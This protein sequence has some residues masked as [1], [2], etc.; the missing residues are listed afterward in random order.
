MS[1]LFKQ[2]QWFF[3]YVLLTLCQTHAVWSQDTSAR[4]NE[5]RQAFG[6]TGDPIDRNNLIANLRAEELKVPE[7]KALLTETLAKEGANRHPNTY[8]I[9]SLFTLISERFD[10]RDSEVLHAAIESMFHNI[11]TPETPILPAGTLAIVLPPKLDE[12]TSEFVRR[13]AKYIENK[14]LTQ[15]LNPDFSL[16]GRPF[17]AESATAYET[18]FADFQAELSATPP[19]SHFINGFSKQ[20]KIFPFTPELV[21]HFQAA[22]E[23]ITTL[24]RAFLS[25][26]TFLSVR[27]IFRESSEHVLR[28]PEPPAVS[29]PTPPV[30][31]AEAA[32]EIPAPIESPPPIEIPVQDRASEI[33]KREV[34]AEVNNIMTSLDQIESLRQQ[35]AAFRGNQVWLMGGTVAAIFYA[36]KERIRTGSTHDPVNFDAIFTPF[37]DFDFAVDGPMSVARGIANRVSEQFPILLRDKGFWEAHTLRTEDGRGIIDDFNFQNQHSD[38]LSLSMMRLE[39]PITEDSFRSARNFDDPND[40]S[41]FETLMSDGNR[42]LLSPNHASTPRANKNPPIVQVMRYLVKVFRYGLVIDDESRQI[43]DRLITES[44]SQD[45]TRFDRHY[46]QERLS[47]LAFQAVLESQSPADTIAY[48]EEKGLAEK[49]RTLD[50]SLRIDNWTTQNHR[51]LFSLTHS[52]LSYIHSQQ[53]G[54]KAVPLWDL[55]VIPDGST[56]IGS[57]R[58]GNGRSSVVVDRRHQPDLQNFI[59]TAQNYRTQ[60]PNEHDRAR[61]IM[62]L[63]T[64]QRLLTGF[65]LTPPTYIPPF[66]CRD[67][68]LIS[69]ILLEAAG[70]RNKIFTTDSRTWNYVFYSDGQIYQFNA[71]GSSL[72]RTNPGTPDYNPMVFVAD[73]EHPEK[74][75]RSA[76]SAKC[77]AKLRGNSS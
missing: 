74:I 52:P 70:L 42:F 5:F 17:D 16:Q 20:L 8:V 48:F 33:S 56:I 31:Q 72:S 60:F 69:H 53:L 73:P 19:N 4:M 32:I 51:W 15:E 6:T 3:F 38:M 10:Y 14:V 62:S 55:E 75:D 36:A 18:F 43:V 2:G 76:R 13:A 71:H 64:Q 9:A 27:A 45:W 59:A 65:Y 35:S 23:K 50:H 41:I 30:L 46:L 66:D 47:I 21:P 39:H 22:A 1:K 77:L 29:E 68:A 61:A 26:N 37:Q 12:K 7:L 28:I 57:Q 34:L 40:H 58:H 67:Y 54:R 44:L 25:P 63:V 49:F 24:E 11:N